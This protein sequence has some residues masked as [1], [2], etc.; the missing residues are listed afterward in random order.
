MIRNFLQIQ[1]TNIYHNQRCD[2]PVTPL[3]H[4]GVFPI[5]FR[6]ISVGLCQY[7]GIIGNE[8]DV[9][10]IV[11]IL[12]CIFKIPIVPYFLQRFDVNKRNSKKNFWQFA[13]GR[14]S[15]ILVIFV[16]V[17]NM[18]LILG[19]ILKICIV[20]YFRIILM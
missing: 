1:T 2:H 15:L 11:W 20:L 18:A 17:D 6:G 19:S 10:S 13:A 4:N 8:F 3:N 16:G 14:T 5:K 7:F 9:G 12:E